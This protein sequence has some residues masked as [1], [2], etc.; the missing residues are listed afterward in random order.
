MKVAHFSSVT[1]VGCALLFASCGTQ[2]SSEV[3]DAGYS[4]FDA[5]RTSNRITPF[6]AKGSA[7]ALHD[8]FLATYTRASDPYLG[9]EDLQQ[10]C[11]NLAKVAAGIGDVSFAEGLSRER[12][13]VINSVRVIGGDCLE[14]YPRTR[15]LIS[16]TPSVKLPIEYAMQ[17]ARTP[18]MIAL[19]NEEG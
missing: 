15:S 12:P 16:T 14:P 19:Q 10:M 5:W 6:A 7:R 3:S 2:T 8:L 11:T 4:A 13:E 17:D 18:L 9:G 1:V